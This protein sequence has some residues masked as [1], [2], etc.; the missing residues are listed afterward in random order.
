MF[1]LYYFDY[2]SDEPN[3]KRKIMISSSVHYI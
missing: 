3:Q 2:T 1:I